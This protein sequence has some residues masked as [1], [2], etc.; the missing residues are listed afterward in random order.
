MILSAVGWRRIYHNS[1]SN[2]FVKRCINFIYPC[3]VI[4]I[5]LFL[6]VVSCYT[7]KNGTEIVISNSVF[8]P[9]TNV[10]ANSYNNSSYKSGPTHCQH[11]ISLYFIPYFM[12]LMAY[13]YALY[14][15][16]FKSSEH[17]DALMEMAFVQA[18]KRQTSIMLQNSILL[19]LRSIFFVCVFWQILMVMEQVVYIILYTEHIGS[20]NHTISHI[21]SEYVFGNTSSC[22]YVYYLALII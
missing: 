20:N 5:L 1:V 2:Y 18:A 8:P 13:M 6:Y 4:L 3:I 16:R 15:F 7:C 19:H 21:E 14:L 12:H 22:N 10:V 17:I 9:L 11:L